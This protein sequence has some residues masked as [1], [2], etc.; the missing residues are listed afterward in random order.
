MSFAIHASHPCASSNPQPIQ[1]SEDVSESKSESKSDTTQIS[2]KVKATISKPGFG[3]L[4]S[5]LTMHSTG[6]I[7]DYY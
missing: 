5:T 2:T 3:G 6:E 4:S 7:E 1:E